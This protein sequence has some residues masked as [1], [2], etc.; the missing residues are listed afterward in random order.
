[1]P[2]LAV[3]IRNIAVETLDILV[4]TF[5]FYKL[6]MLIQDTR[7]VQVLKGLII[8]SLITILAQILQLPVLRWIMGGFWTIG[9]ITAVIVFQPELRNALAQIGAN[10]FINVFLRPEFVQEISQAVENCSRNKCGALIVI[11]RGTGLRSYAETGVKVN[12]EVSA[13]LLGTIFTPNS[14]LHDGAVIIR[15]DRLA[16]AACVLPL[17]RN[18][19]LPRSL[20]MRHR[21]AL[22]L[23]EE[24]DAAIIVVSEETGEISLIHDKQNLANIKIETLNKEITKLY[25]NTTPKKSFHWQWKPSFNR[26]DLLSNLNIKLI[27]LVMALILWCFVKYFWGR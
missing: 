11:E 20:G 13:E 1:M 8:L 16:A 23:T 12:G 7:A 27:S 18:R 26:R 22:G 17:S 2:T 19:D 10:R 25:A 15:H 6:F 24:T 21:A 4:V 9:V 3:I 5:L 14:P